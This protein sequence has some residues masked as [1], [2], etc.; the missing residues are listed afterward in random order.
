MLKSKAVALLVAAL[1]ISVLNAQSLTSGR[2]TNKSYINTYF[3]FAYTWPAMLE[4]SP[5]PSP[6]A[7]SADP[8]AYQFPL[9]IARQGNQ[10]YGVV[11]VAQRLNVAGPHS[12][13][14]TK[15]ADLIDRIASSLR[16]GPILSNINRTEKKGSD[17]QVFD[18]L[19]YLQSGKPSLIL[20]TKI[21]EYLIVFKCN[22]QSAT[23]LRAMENSAL[24]LRLLK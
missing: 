21:G 4:P 6:G 24:A 3:H 18:E 10:P 17:G 2:T 7:Q 5:L 23:D 15:S 14:L 1:S 11:V 12:A 13:P 22:A 16:P 20:A 8:H 19:S 9:F